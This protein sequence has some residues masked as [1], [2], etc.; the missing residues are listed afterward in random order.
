MPLY[1]LR[2]L[3]CKHEGEVILPLDASIPR[4]GKCQAEQEKVICAPA[5]IKIDNI[6]IKYKRLGGFDPPKSWEPGPDE[7]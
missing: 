6:P 7:A 4:C 3:N 1:K 2:C 5:K